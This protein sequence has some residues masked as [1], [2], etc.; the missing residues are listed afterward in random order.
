MQKSSVYI[1]IIPFIDHSS[2][3][4]V[5]PFPN[6]QVESQISSESCT[7]NADLNMGFLLLDVC[8]LPVGYV[9]R[10]F[11]LTEVMVPQAA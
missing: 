10:L 2:E 3:S 9:I 1:V 6:L 8:I 4:G 11:Q 5:I 7:N